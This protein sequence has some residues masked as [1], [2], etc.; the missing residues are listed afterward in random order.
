MIQ[1]G[2]KFVLLNFLY[3]AHKVRAIEMIL[4]SLISLKNLF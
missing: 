2:L 4:V 1:Y 3:V